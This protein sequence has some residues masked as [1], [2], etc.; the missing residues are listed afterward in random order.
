MVKANRMRTSHFAVAQ[1]A[2][3]VEEGA[4]ASM[5][6]KAL[7]PDALP[8]RPSGGYQL[9][10]WVT[11]DWE[12]F[13]ELSQSDDVDD[14]LEA[15]SLIR[16]PP[17]DGVPSGTY[18]WAFSEFFVSEMEVAVASLVTRFVDQLHK[19]GDLERALSAVRQGLRAVA[20]DYGLWELYLSMAAQ[21]GPA[22]L[23]RARSEARAALGAVNSDVLIL[24]HWDEQS[25]SRPPVRFLSCYS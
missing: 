13:A 3:G 6:R 12:R 23:S 16:G 15:L 20:G 8:L 18:A 2:S 21:A 7:G 5:L 24:E 4:L 9:A 14:A 19:V 10:S 17:F 22:V 11:T 1:A 25:G